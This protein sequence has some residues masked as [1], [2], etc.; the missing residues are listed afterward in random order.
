MAETNKYR[1]ALNNLMA[2]LIGIF[3]APISVF[4]LKGAAAIILSTT[5]VFKTPI[6]KQIN[7]LQVKDVLS[8]IVSTSV[9]LLGV[10]FA[11]MIILYNVKDKSSPYLRI[12]V[13]DLAATIYLLP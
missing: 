10:L 3:F 8:H 5:V 2:A 6:I 12:L 9:T 7:L 11:A 4:G 1:K 13:N